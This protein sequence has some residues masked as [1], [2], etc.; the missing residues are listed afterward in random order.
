MS[1]FTSDAV[2]G[3]VKT[4]R[5]VEIGENFCINPR[6]TE[7]LDGWTS[8]NAVF[9]PISRVADPQAY[10][11]YMLRIFHST[12]QYTFIQYTTEDVLPSYDFDVKKIL[13]AFRIK[14]VSL[15]GGEQKIIKIE[16]AAGTAPINYK[17]IVITNKVKRVAMVFEWNNVLG[18]PFFN[19]RFYNGN[20]FQNNGDIRIDDVYINVVIQDYNFECCDETYLT[21][22]K[23][24]VGQHELF[25]GKIQQYNKRW[26]P[27]FYAH[28]AVLNKKQEIYRQSI[29]ESLNN[30]FIF[31]HIDFMWGFF[32]IWD[33][34]FERRY[35]FNKYIGHDSVIVIKGSEM[36]ID[37]VAPTAVG[38]IM[39]VTTYILIIGSW[40]PSNGVFINITPLDYNNQSS[41]DTSFV[42]EFSE[43]TNVI[44]TAPATVMDGLI[45]RNFL[46][47][48]D[49]N[50]NILS[51]EQSYQVTMNADKQVFAVYDDDESEGYGTDYG[52]E[53][54]GYGDVL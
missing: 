22:D 47:W 18:Y 33:E 32:G 49:E 29:A 7:N 10:E 9:L 17:E 21:F 52:G 38:Y 39:P 3:G 31:P 44:L 43:N 23:T 51:T 35:S 8:N 41:G 26:R 37:G 14:D 13:V 36:L 11:E 30:L 6:L 28:Y 1:D 20:T 25:D 34:N 4:P 19:L 50:Q 12:S 15:N 24:T 5:I 40:N 16:L 48:I 53:T 46:H 45:E 27:N 54:D 2:V 42:R